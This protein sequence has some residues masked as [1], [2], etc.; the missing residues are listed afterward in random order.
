MLVRSVLCS[1]LLLAVPAAAIADPPVAGASNAVTEWATIVQPAIHSASAPRS[2]GTSQILHTM[3][4]LAVYDATVA[5][6]GGYRPYAAAI[7]APRGADVRAAVA[8]AA[9][10]TARARINPSRYD[11]LDEQYA[12]YMAAIGEGR[13]KADGVRAGEAAAAAVLALRGGDGFDNVV[14]YYCSAVPPA[15]GDFEPDTGCPTAPTS[16]QP[17]DAKVGQI[18]PFTFSEPS[19]LRP[20][21][22]YPLTSEAYAADFAETA[23]FGRA[24]S[25]VRTPDQTDAA[26]FWSEHPYVFWNRNL[27]NLAIRMR[28]N[29]R[30]SARFLAMVHTAASDGIIVGFESKY[31]FNAWRPRTAIPQAGDDGN[32]ATQGDPSWTPLLRVNHP[33]YPSGHGFWSTAVIEA[34]AAFVGSKKFPLTLQAEVPE[35]VRKSRSYRNLQE[36]QR[37][38]GNARVWGGLHWRQAIRDGEQIGEAVARH[39][40][41]HS[42]RRCHGMPGRGTC[43]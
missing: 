40:A 21:G 20:R 25:S 14:P 31:F 22:P 8:T 17:V 32:P 26:Y 36:L 13:A 11:Y 39:V 4:M 1:A 18:R 23:A 38:I 30:D 37:E 35:L 19:R 16:P 12:A 24:D 5:I 9:Y 28:L 27:T 6:E 15:L 41:R 42:F 2:A 3:V 43:R 29:V 10:V 34:V 33:E 7:R